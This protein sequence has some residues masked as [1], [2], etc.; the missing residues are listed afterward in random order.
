MRYVL[1]ILVAIGIMAFIVLFI[2]G[3]FV[4]YNI[5]HYVFF[6]AS[7]NTNGDIDECIGCK[8]SSCKNCKLNNYKEE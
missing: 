3:F 8:N 7:K 2:I 1:G 5:I 6:E 4:V